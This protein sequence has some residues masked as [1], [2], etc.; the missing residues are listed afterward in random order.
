MEFILIKD[1]IC[2]RKH[3]TYQPIILFTKQLFIILF[4]SAFII[5]CGPTEDKSKHDFVRTENGEFINVKLHSV[6]SNLAKSGSYLFQMK[7]TPCHK[8][9]S[10]KLIGPGLKSITTRRKPEWIL[11]MIANPMLMTRND[12]IAKELL[13]AYL[14]Q[15]P[16]QQYNSD[17]EIIALLEFLILN[18]TEH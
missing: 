16:N 17:E 15:M 13:K 12:S 5:K 18:D 10:E 4:L 9:N 2:L 3:L 6:D 7:C 11:N 1:L 14:I 8:L